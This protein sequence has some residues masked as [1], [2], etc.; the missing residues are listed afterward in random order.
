M[1]ASDNQPVNRALQLRAE[2]L[3][4]CQRAAWTPQ[5]IGTGLFDAGVKEIYAELRD[6][7]TVRAVHVSQD[8]I[9]CCRRHGL[10]T[11]LFE[12]A[13]ARIW[14]FLGDRDRAE[15]RWRE[16][17][18]HQD[19]NLRRIAQEALAGLQ[20][21][22]DSGAQLA[23]DVA[24]ALDRNDQERLVT[25]L[26]EAA[27]AEEASASLDQVLEAAALQWPMPEEIPWNRGLFTN[28]LLLDLFE[29]QLQGWE[30]DCGD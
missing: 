10:W 3:Q 26:L 19:P 21:N 8:L 18:L 28:Q 23:T 22:L 6:L 15:A 2:A 30:A 7:Q 12:D 11:P 20:D 4:I 17:L 5:C 14:M 13:E 29:R 24:Q 25:I 1:P 16:L 9:A 27:L